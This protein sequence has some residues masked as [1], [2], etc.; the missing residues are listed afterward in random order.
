[1][2]DSPSRSEASVACQ[3]WPMQK[4]HLFYPAHCKSFILLFCPKLLAC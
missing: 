3:H 1:M 2:S 4:G